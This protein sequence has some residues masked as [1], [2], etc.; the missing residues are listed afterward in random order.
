MVLEENGEYKIVRESRVLIC[1]GKKYQNTNE[2]EGYRS[3]RGGTGQM[4]RDVTERPRKT[5]KN[6]LLLAFIIFCII[7]WTLLAEEGSSSDRCKEIQ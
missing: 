7:L 5:Y 4:L 6:V 3:R 2:K 1:S